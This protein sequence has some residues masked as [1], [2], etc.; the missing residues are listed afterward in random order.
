MEG[1]C[2]LMTK[3]ERFKKHWVALMGNEVY[4]Y[5]TREDQC[6]IF[7]HS[8]AGTFIKELSQTVQEPL[9][10]PLKIIF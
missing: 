7:M 9:L 8:L 4:F 3:A 6:H 5:K 1:E 10:W 2:L